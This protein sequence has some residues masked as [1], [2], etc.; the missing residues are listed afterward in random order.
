MENTQN[1]IQIMI[2]SLKKK[3]MVLDDISIQNEKQYEAAQAQK[4]DDEAME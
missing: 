1:Y 4:L 2:N 3:V